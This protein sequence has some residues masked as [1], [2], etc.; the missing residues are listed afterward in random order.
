MVNDLV[1]ELFKESF[2]PLMSEPYKSGILINLILLGSKFI[3]NRKLEYTFNN[4]HK[5][6]C[7]TFFENERRSAIENRSHYEITSIVK[8]S[9]NSLSE[10]KLELGL[11]TCLVELKNFFYAAWNRKGFKGMQVIA[12]PACAYL[13]YLY[14]IS[15]FKNTNINKVIITNGISPYSK[16]ATLAARKSTIPCAYLEHTV[17]PICVIEQLL[18][19]DEVITNQE[20]TRKL[21]KSHFKKK[22]NG[23]YKEQKIDYKPCKDRNITRIALCLNESDDL[24]L[25]IKA[26]QLFYTSNIEVTF[27]LKSSDKRIKKIKNNNKLFNISLTSELN[28]FNFI[29]S[30]Q[31]VIAGNSNVVYDCIKQNTRVLYLHNGEHFDVYGLISE[32]SIETAKTPQSLIEIISKS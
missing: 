14:F 25:F 24:D 19:F 15:I 23:Y 13:Y 8:Y 16:A 11:Y 2:D 1:D 9:T 31:V 6:T 22:I 4:G 29:K 7:F 20:F 28:I 21:I 18:Y 30:Q 26:A 5:N 3:L 27:R 12:N 17:T 10:V 32:Y